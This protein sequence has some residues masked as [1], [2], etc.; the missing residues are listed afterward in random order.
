MEKIYKSS[1][2]HLRSRFNQKDSFQL[3]L[4]KT[5]IFTTS[6]N[7]YKSRIISRWTPRWTLRRWMAVLLPMMSICPVSDKELVALVGITLRL[8]IQTA[9]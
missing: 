7:T 2:Y 5:P 3:P 1:S 4:K 9:L 8:Q 6:N